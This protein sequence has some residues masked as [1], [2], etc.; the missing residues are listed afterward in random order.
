M[1][2][3]GAVKVLND[4]IA[5]AFNRKRFC[6]ISREEGFCRNTENIKN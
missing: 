3:E 6:Q 4:Y 5:P 1:D 2:A